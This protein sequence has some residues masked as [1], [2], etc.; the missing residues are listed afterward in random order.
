MTIEGV[1][2]KTYGDGAEYLFRS[3][4]VKVMR[5]LECGIAYEMDIA[6]FYSYVFT[7]SENGSF[8]VRATTARKVFPFDLTENL[9]RF[10]SSEFVGVVIRYG[11]SIKRKEG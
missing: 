3:A 4:A 8:E 5:S 2:V 9:Y 1:N 11:T 10:T 7:K 6:G